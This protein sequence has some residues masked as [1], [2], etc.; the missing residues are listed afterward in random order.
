MTIESDG[1]TEIAVRRIVYDVV[2]AG[3]GTAG[4]VIAGRLT[5]RGARVLLLEAGG[6][7]DHENVRNAE[8]SATLALWQEGA[9][10][11]DYRTTPQPGLAGRT[12][13]LPQGRVL[14]GGSSVNAL[15]HVRGNRRDFDRWARLGNEGWG[16]H[17]VLPWFIASEDYAGAP[18]P[19]RGTG[20]NLH[21]TPLHRPSEAARAFVAAADQLGFTAGAGA[22]FDYNGPRQENV[23]F[24]YQSTRGPDG[25]RSSTASAYLGA[26]GGDT[27]APDVIT[28]ATVTRVLLRADRA[29]GVEF[30][31]HGSR[32]RAFAAEQV[33]L[34]CGA[35]ATPKI[36]M[37]SGLGPASHLREHGITPVADLPGVGSNLQDHLLAPVAYAGRRA[38][39]T[40]R[41]LAEAGL[42]TWSRPGTRDD[43]PDLQFLVGPVQYVPDRYRRPGPGL[44]IAAVLTQ[45]RSRGTVRLRSADPFT[46][47]AVDPHYLEDPADVSVLLRGIHLARATARTA[48]LAELCGDE[49]A[50]GVHDRAGL[51]RYLRAG[52]STVWH[53]AGTCRMG[54]DAEAVVDTALRVHGVTGL[55]IAD[56]SVMPSVTSGNTNAPTVMIA[57]RAAALTASDLPSALGLD[58]ISKSTGALMP[59]TIPAR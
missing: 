30:Q 23:P 8:L 2:V 55:R 36:L 53:P 18:S 39:G 1:R 57:E 22:H 20:G 13:A 5:A 26:R 42:F 31:H 25:R 24:Y 40:P 44:T 29:V 9:H 12:L 47:P 33:I 14:G 45:P 7:D 34:T 46:A 17:D 21:V 51:V 15:L 10:T 59:R 56:A 3:G 35:L 19:Y 11:W 58:A 41:L 38:T 43:P 32:R 27:A 49:L 16:Y 50:P 52:V 6:P 48:P 37:L 54:N 28:G 4:C